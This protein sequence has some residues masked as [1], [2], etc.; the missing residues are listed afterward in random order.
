MSVELRRLLMMPNCYEAVTVLFASGTG[1]A[2]LRDLI[3]PHI[4]EVFRRVDLMVADERELWHL[5][6]TALVHEVPLSLL[7]ILLKTAG[8]SDVSTQVVKVVSGFGAV[9][10]ARG[11]Q[12]LAV[13]VQERAEY[14]RELLLFEIAHE[15]H[16]TDAMHKAAILGGLE[17]D[18]ARWQVRLNRC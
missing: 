11:D 4:L 1:S 14:L 8:F 6:V 9:W 10:R 15:G 16:L 2:T 12:E 17:D 13:Y 7:Q 5:R 3:T 18:L